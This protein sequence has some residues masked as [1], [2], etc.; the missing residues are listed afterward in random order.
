MVPCLEVFED[1]INLYPGEPT[2]LKL[3]AYSKATEKGFQ[4]GIG[5]IGLIA[6][7]ALNENSMQK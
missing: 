2:S 5:S 1:L 6:T 7:S 3:K 4:V